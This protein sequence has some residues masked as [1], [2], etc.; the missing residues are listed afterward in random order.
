MSRTRNTSSVSDNDV[1]DTNMK[2]LK[3]TELL[4][5]Y[6]VVWQ[7]R[8]EALYPQVLADNIGPVTL[9]VNDLNAKLEAKER[10]ITESCDGGDI[11]TKN[12]ID[13]WSSCD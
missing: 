5:N 10:P 13:D 1:Q 8:G 7:L 6:S 3:S 2:L 12:G 11:T 4:N 9:T